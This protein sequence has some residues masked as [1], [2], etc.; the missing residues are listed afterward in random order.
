M[1]I[2]GSLSGKRD[3]MSGEVWLHS[4]GPGGGKVKEEKE[5]QAPAFP[6]ASS[7]SN[8]LDSSAPFC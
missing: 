3:R 7:Q 8:G 6:G 4:L 1:V 5:P 2:S